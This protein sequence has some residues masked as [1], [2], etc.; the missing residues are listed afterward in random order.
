[1]ATGEEH[2]V[3]IIA[4]ISGYTQFMVSSRNELTHGQWI[5]GEL[6]QTI[7]K[8]VE[9][10]LEVAKLEGDAVFLYAI[11]EHHQMDWEAIRR[12]IGAKLLRFFE[13][14]S[15]KVA[16]LSLS[17]QCQCGACSNIDKLKLKLIA[18]SGVALFYQMGRFEELS[19]V[20]VIIV[21]RLL[22]NSVPA[23]EYIL[24]T[25]SA[26]RDIM[27]PEQIAVTE[28]AEQYEAIGNVKTYTYFP[29]SAE[30][31]IAEYKAQHKPIAKDWNNRLGL[32]TLLTKLGLRRAGKFNHLPLLSQ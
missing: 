1:M 16:E 5:I 30:K 18:H 6:V 14:F 7:I 32:H 12:Q 11:K 22:K 20:D 25:E 19:G 28:G 21:H 3:L 13:V 27:F 24:L 31:Y 15:S 26:Y 2:V 23:H 17:H 4:D 8:Q 9:I 29:P 10:P